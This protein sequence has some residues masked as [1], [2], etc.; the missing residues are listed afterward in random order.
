MSGKH[1]LAPWLHECAYVLN[2][3]PVLSDHADQLAFGG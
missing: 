2:A 1:T 3:K